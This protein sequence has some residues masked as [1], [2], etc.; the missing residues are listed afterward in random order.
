MLISIARDV[1]GAP[2]SHIQWQ[3]AEELKGLGVREG[4]RV[5]RVGGLY[6]ASW[7]RLAGLTVIAEVPRSDAAEFWSSAPRNQAEVIGTFRALGVQAIIAEQ[8]SPL[9][10]VCQSCTEWRR[11]GSGR[12]SV[13]VF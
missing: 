12:F 3:V 6:A 2:S 8:T 5:A 9:D 7:A 10:G 4:A 1:S 13:L 11:L